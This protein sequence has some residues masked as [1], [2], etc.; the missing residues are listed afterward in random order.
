MPFALVAEAL[1]EAARLR[2]PELGSFIDRL[3]GRLELGFAGRCVRSLGAEA[4]ELAVESGQLP[5]LFSDELALGPELSAEPF[6]LRVVGCET[7]S[8]GAFRVSF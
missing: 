2:S 3:G 4:I 7:L 8:V 6:R 1:L 5:V